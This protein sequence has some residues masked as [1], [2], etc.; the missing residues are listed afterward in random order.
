[1]KKSSYIHLLISLGLL[2]GIGQIEPIA[3]IT[4]QGMQLLGIFV[5]TIYAWITI[6]VVWPSILAMFTLFLYG[7]VTP[8]EFFA[9]SFGNDVIVFLI[10][11]F[12]FTGVIEEVGLT[13]YL[14]N[15]LL[16]LSIVKKSPWMLIFILFST[17]YILA[18]F[19]SIYPV[20]ILLWSITYKI[21]DEAGYA[22]YSKFAT[23]ILSGIVIAGAQSS[24]LW[25]FKPTG[26]VLFGMYT[27]LTG[28]SIDILQ[29]TLYMFAMGLFTVLGYMFLCKFVFRLDVSDLKKVSN[30]VEK[31]TMTFAQKIVLFFL[32]IFVTLAILDGVLPNAEGLGMIL[33]RIGSPGIVMGLIVLMCLIHI[34][35]KPLLN[36]P[37]TAKKFVVWDIIIILSLIL[38][39]SNM[40]MTDDAGIKQWMIQFLSPMVSGTN[41]IVFI[42]LVLL[43]PALCTNFASNT[44]IAVIFCQLIVSMAPMVGVNAVPLIIA[45]LSLAHYAFLTPAAS[46]HAAFLFANTEWLDKKDLTKYCGISV[47]VLSIFGFLL[48]FPLSALIF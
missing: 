8:K 1:M 6:S 22:P 30:L 36:F 45:M 48:Y 10:F 37:K 24:C 25:F 27:S 39:L 13:K 12:V 44:V 34:D 28:E 42:A 26:M 29:Y 23:L 40:L 9:I 19:T 14:T 46:G 32:V 35:G 41:V 38:P 2:I 15:C 16:D 17:A 43:L 4:Q 31:E 5:G 47:L 18:S 7:I 20:A 3:P 33:A 11:T 21:C